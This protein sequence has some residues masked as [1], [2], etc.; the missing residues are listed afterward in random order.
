MRKRSAI[1]AVFPSEPDTRS[2]NTHQKNCL[3]TAHK[4]SIRQ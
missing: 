1:F 2:V 3:S 4:S